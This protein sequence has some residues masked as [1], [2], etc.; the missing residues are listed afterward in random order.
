MLQSGGTNIKSHEQCKSSPRSTSSSILRIVR[1]AHFSQS[2]EYLKVPR[3]DLNISFSLLLTRLSTFSYACWPINSS[4]C[5]VTV[6]TFCP[7]F[8][9]VVWLFRINL[10]VFFVY[11]RGKPF[12]VIC[13]ANILSPSVACLFMPFDAGVFWWTQVLDFTVVQLISL[14]QWMFVL[15]V[16]ITMPFPTSQCY[17]LKLLVS[18]FSCRSTTHPGFAFVCGTRQGFNFIL[19]YGSL[20]VLALLHIC[21]STLTHLSQ[22]KCPYMLLVESGLWLFV[23]SPQLLLLGQQTPNI[24]G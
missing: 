22:I 1:L 21:P 3:C 15:W 2:D 10:Y 24:S 16:L 19:S 18:P 5:E 14:L 20:I 23:L 7:F 13:T 8:Y 11:S 9:R 6:Q 4:I 17:L 12:A